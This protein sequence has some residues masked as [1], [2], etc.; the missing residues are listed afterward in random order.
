MTNIIEELVKRHYV[1]VQN[2]ILLFTS[3]FHKC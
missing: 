3:H 2:Q 1:T